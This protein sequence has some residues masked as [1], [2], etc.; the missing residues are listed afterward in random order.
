MGVTY[1]AYHLAKPRR[2]E[3]W[4][5]S[6]LH[7]FFPLIDLQKKPHVRQNFV[8]HSLF[9]PH[10]KEVKKNP[11]HFDRPRLIPRH[12]RTH[13][14]RIHISRHT[15]TASFEHAFS[16]YLRR[17]R[18]VR[19]KESVFLLVVVVAAAAGGMRQLLFFHLFLWCANFRGVF[20]SCQIYIPLKHIKIEM[21]KSCQIFVIVF[22]H[23]LKVQ[24]AADKWTDPVLVFPLSDYTSCFKG[25]EKEGEIFQWGLFSK[26]PVTLQLGTSL[27]GNLRSLALYSLSGGKVD[28]FPEWF[29]C[30]DNV[31]EKVKLHV[32]SFLYQT[33]FISL[34]S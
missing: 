32:I 18:Q 31:R 33:I 10:T 2:R 28:D 30:S 15:F 11:R 24:G 9:P 21:F 25:E 22:L 8:T 34:T 3:M 12:A 6:F 13:F 19:E 1:G 5:S 14:S 27:Y 26:I 16:F 20:K 23:F 17:G 7:A 29:C 4:H